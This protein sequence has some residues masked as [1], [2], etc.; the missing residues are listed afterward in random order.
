[1]ESTSGGP[2]TSARMAHRLLIN[3]YLFATHLVEADNLIGTGGGTRTH[4]TMGLNHVAIPIRL[5][6][7][8]PARPAVIYL[9]RYLSPKIKSKVIVSRSV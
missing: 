3:Q 7:H 6:P 2:L 1:M 4:R 5:R 8:M 9:R